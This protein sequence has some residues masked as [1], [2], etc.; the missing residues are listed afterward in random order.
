MF[1]R[2]PD[3]T[4]VNIDAGFTIGENQYGP[5]WLR[6]AT[7]QQRTLLGIV[8]VEV[9]TFDDRF[10]FA[11]DLPRPL[12]DCKSMRF[13]DL[14]MIRFTAETGGASFAGG[15]ISSDRDTQ[16]VLTAART[17][18]KENPAYTVN[19]KSGPGVFV[20]LD[21][22]TIIAMADAVAA[23]VQACFDREMELTAELNAATDLA[24]LLAID[25]RAGWPA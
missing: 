11:P 19:W 16:R 24:A 7:P 1:F 2:L 6:Q 21:A 10:F 5:G 9:P 15:T 4:L 12:T 14:A 18:A 20:E 23:H 3:N 13:N 8:E 25:L 22:P 17:L